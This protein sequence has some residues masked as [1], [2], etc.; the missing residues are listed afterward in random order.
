MYNDDV[1]NDL[2]ALL[3]CALYIAI[4]HNLLTKLAVKYNGFCFTK[5]EQLK[6]ILECN[7]QILVKDCAKTC[8]DILVT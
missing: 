2:H 3:E 8:Q 4:K 5:K 1:E 6:L 7:D